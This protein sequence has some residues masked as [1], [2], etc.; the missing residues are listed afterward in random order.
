MYSTCLFCHRGLGSNEAVERFT[1]GRRIAFDASKGRLWVVC[2][3]CTRWNLSPIEERWEVI[4]ECERLFRDTRLRVSTDNIGLA[5]VPDGT[6]LV[7]VG[8]PQRPELAAWRYGEHFRRRRRKNAVYMGASIA[9]TVPLMMTGALTAIATAIPGGV[10]VLQVPTWLDLYRQKR[11]IIAR[12]RTDEGERAL[13][14]GKHLRY[15]RLTTHEGDANGLSWR[16]SVRHEK[17]TLEISG[18][19]A[20]QV[21]G[22][23]LARINK[24]G[25]SPK[26][27]QRAVGRLE[28]EGESQ[29]LF[30]RIASNPVKESSGFVQWWSQTGVDTGGDLAGTLRSLALSDRLALEMATHEE[31]ER[32]A[33]EGELAALQNAWR[34]AE[35]IAS[36]ADALFLPEHIQAFI[37]RYRT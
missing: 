12:T 34:D 21:A 3:R 8:S 10:F 9:V 14:R 13:V 20:I 15:A 23:I 17:G 11:A 7:R 36:I 22:K 32:R 6:D 5:R 4:D 31:G 18:S 35:E 27:V 28:H 33:L 37:R 26:A 24:V 29:R 16:L 19:E 30:E 1:V 25:G 2:S